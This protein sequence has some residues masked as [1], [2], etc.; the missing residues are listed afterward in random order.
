MPCDKYYSKHIYVR[1]SRNWGE[2]EITFVENLR[3][4][5]KSW[6]DIKRMKGIVKEGTAYAKEGKYET[7]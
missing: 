2:A 6:R 5:T 7:V 3:E 1:H 4:L